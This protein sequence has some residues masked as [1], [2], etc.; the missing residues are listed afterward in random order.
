MHDAVKAVLDDAAPDRRVCVRGEGMGWL[1]ALELQAR[2]G[3]T[4]ATL[5]RQ[6]DHWVGLRRFD[7][8]AEVY[9]DAIRLEDA[10]F[11]GLSLVRNT[12]FEDD[13]QG[14]K[15]ARIARTGEYSLV[16]TNKTS[17]PQD[18]A[19]GA[20]GRLPKGMTFVFGGFVRNEAR[21]LERAG[22]ALVS[23][24]NSSY[25]VRTP[26]L[27]Q[28]TPRWEFVW[29][30]AAPVGMGDKFMFKRLEVSGLAEGAVHAGGIFFCGVDV[31]IKR[32][33]A[34]RECRGIE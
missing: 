19:D 25:V 30:C 14:L 5:P 34:P 20:P 3:F 11:R 16:I 2:H 26:P 15:R 28:K 31:L 22:M 4:V 27:R 6:E 7:S 13:A 12:S 24:N 18:R 33:R 29:N 10:L 32:V 23:M 17:Q 1:A 9:T 21:S 8:P